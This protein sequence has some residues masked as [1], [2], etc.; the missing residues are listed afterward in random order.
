MIK[1]ENNFAYIDG[2]NLHKG[3]ADLGWR[4]DYK[5]FR[6]WLKEKYS[7]E[8]AYLFIGLVPKNKDLY[9]FLQEAGFTLVFKETTCN[10]EGKVKGNCD[11]DLVLKAVVDYFEKQF[12]QAV[13]VTSDGD[14]AGLVKFF[15]EKNV[16]RSL[17]APSNKCSFLLRKLNIPLVYLDAQKNRL[18]YP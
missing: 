13:L 5:R 17:I 3:V 11:A 15:K 10:S 6:I 2:A 9:T 1:K 12:N 4:L 18:N 8:R 14:Y 16:F 7:V